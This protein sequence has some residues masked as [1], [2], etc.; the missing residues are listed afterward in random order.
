MEIIHVAVFVNKT[1]FA[2]RFRN[3][4]T[5]IGNIDMA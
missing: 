1:E 4:F 3:N 5:D 2:P